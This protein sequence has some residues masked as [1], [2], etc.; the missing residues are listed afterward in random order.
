MSLEFLGQCHAGS[1]DLEVS[2]SFWCLSC[3]RDCKES[4]DNSMI[5]SNQFSSKD[6]ALFLIRELRGHCA[7]LKRSDLV[8]LGSQVIFSRVD[9]VF[10]NSGDGFIELMSSWMTNRR[11]AMLSFGF[12]SPSSVSSFSSSFGL[13]GLINPTVILG[14]STSLSP[15]CPSFSCPS[16]HSSPSCSTS[17]SDHWLPLLATSSRMLNSISHLLVCFIGSVEM[18]FVKLSSS[19][20]LNI[21]HTSLSDLWIELGN[22]WSCW[23]IW[24]SRLASCLWVILR[25][26]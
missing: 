12:F 25:L 17:A 19:E 24:Y 1:K 14:S 7:E 10:H 8:Y 4:R 18:S 13:V 20:L 23:P 16:C 22:C 5:Q 21:F 2:N 26:L 15:Y 9:W 3:R 11:L 6:V